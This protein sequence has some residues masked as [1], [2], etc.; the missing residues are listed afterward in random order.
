MTHSSRKS[1]KQK[2]LE[3]KANVDLNDESID[4]LRRAATALD[5]AEDS[6]QREF[7]LVRAVAEEAVYLLEMMD[8]PDGKGP[9]RLD[10]IRKPIDSHLT[11]LDGILIL[12]RTRDLL[13]HATGR[14]GMLGLTANKLLANQRNYESM[15]NNL[16]RPIER[17]G[18]GMLASYHIGQSPNLKEKEYVIEKPGKNPRLHDYEYETDNS[19][20][21]NE[22]EA[23]DNDND[24]E[25]AAVV[26]YKGPR[27][28]KDS[29][30]TSIEIS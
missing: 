9:M 29:K 3:A 2:W 16:Q 27:A 20:S 1:Y 22:V 10:D 26:Q 13:K 18:H 28:R 21:E 12:R 5:S 23:S 15:T 14:I 8:H 25:P 4:T 19:D 11:E 24:A 6:R 30:E 17:L 7:E